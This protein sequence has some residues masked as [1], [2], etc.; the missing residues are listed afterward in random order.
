MGSLQDEAGLDIALPVEEGAG[1]RRN[2][3]LLSA[4]D[5]NALNFCGFAMCVE[6]GHE[7]NQEEKEETLL[8]AVP[9]AL[10]SDSVYIFARSSLGFMKANHKN[11]MG[12]SIS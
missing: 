7:S 8:V 11:M 10:N 12:R 1:H 6:R 4:L 9:S 5:V 2:P 3:W